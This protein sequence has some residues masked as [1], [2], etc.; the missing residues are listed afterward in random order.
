[1]A[2]KAE[3]RE[4]VGTNA[5]RKVRQAGAIPCVVYGEGGNTHIAINRREFEAE[6]KKAGIPGAYELELD[7][8]TLKV[9]IANLDKD[10]LKDEFYTVDFKLA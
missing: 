10:A 9:E 6:L 4:V 7:G 5:S 1:M 2:L 3:L 8:K